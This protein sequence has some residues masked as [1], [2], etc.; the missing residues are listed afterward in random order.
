MAGA[1]GQKLVEKVRPLAPE[2]ADHSAH[3]LR[4]AQESTV[5]RG[6]LAG[7][8]LPIE[9]DPHWLAIFGDPGAIPLFELDGIVAVS[10]GNSNG[11]LITRQQSSFYTVSICAVDG[12]VPAPHSMLGYFRAACK[13]P[14]IP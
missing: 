5:L 2:Y 11:M 14:V 3:S 6:R 1:C 12:H 10:Y 13:M 8:L 9:F 4:R 7:A